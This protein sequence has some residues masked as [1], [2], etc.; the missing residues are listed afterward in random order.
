MSFGVRR[1]EYPDYQTDMLS[2]FPS[3]PY[4]TLHSSIPSHILKHNHPTCIIVNRPLSLQETLH[5]QWGQTCSNQG[6]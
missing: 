2:I 5:M 6:E 1:M 3:P 4:S